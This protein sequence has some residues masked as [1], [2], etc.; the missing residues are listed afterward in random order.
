VVPVAST[1]PA[2]C[3]LVARSVNRL[4]PTVIVA[5][6]PPPARVSAVAIAVVSATVVVPAAAPAVPA[7]VVVPA[8]VTALRERG[9]G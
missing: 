7:V 5:V 6:V 8:L 4:V 9:R 2:R 3:R 1:H